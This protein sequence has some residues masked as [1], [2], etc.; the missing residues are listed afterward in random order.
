MSESGDTLTFTDP[1][2][3]YFY[4]MAM[5]Y[6][7]HGIL[8]SKYKKEIANDMRFIQEIIN[9]SKS[10]TIALQENNTTFNK[11]KNGKS[12]I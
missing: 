10:R 12:F 6:D 8:P 7:K 4:Q 11:L 9:V 5:A 2:Q 3:I 1:R